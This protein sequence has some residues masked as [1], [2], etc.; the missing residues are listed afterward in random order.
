MARTFRVEMTATKIVDV[1]LEDGDLGPNDS[2][3]EETAEQLARDNA[4]FLT[5]PQQVDEVESWDLSVETVIE[6][7]V[8][9]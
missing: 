7:K 2:D 8:A 9:A 6:R 5:D 3:L 1:T 4:F